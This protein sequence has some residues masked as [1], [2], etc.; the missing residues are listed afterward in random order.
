MNV[1]F[2][3]DERMR[4]MLA[5]VFGGILFAQALPEGTLAT[6]KGRA[7]VLN[8]CGACHGLEQVMAH[9][10]SRKGWDMLVHNMAERGMAATDVELKSMVEYL[11]EA[12]PTL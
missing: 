5:T 10:A 2:S 1:C 12:F 4:W 8:R 9:H 6:A 11:A 7:L 3:Y